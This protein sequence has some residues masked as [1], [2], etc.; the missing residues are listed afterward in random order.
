MPWVTEEQIAKA[1]Q[2]DILEYLLAHEPNNL[3]KTGHEYRLR[4]HDSL[5]VSNGKWHWHSRGFGGT[6]ALN[7]LIRVRG[8]E[9]TEA[10][11]TLV[12]EAR[13]GPFPTV[14]NKPLPPKKQKAFTLPA[15]NC[16]NDRAT[17]YLRSRGIDRDILRQCVETN[18]LYEGHKYHNCV[19]VGQ[20]D[21]KGKVRFACV[22]AITGGF[23]QD[24]EGS[25]KQYSF[26]LP[27]SSPP[28][29]VVMVAE[30]PIDALSMATMQKNRSNG[31]D[32]QHYLS[33]SGVSPLALL[34]FLWEHSQVNHIVLGLDKDK[35][36]LKAVEKIRTAVYEDEKLRDRTLC[37]TVS[38]P[39]TGKD[40]NDT[41]LAEIQAQKEQRSRPNRAAFSI[42]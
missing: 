28:G 23:R 35:A 26:L 38:P 37:I 7:Y 20:Q 32:S 21:K 33:L 29:E 5:T 41:L 27:A 9:F 2:V 31:W 22:R 15:R 25:D 36:G 40:Y 11:Q 19:F 17:A 24:I 14:P 10:V 30:A 8:M 16:N 3:K 18:I 34:H 6:T 13:A 4:D 42:M 12:Y 1:K 39:H